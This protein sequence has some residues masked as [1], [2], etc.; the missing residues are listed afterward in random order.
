MLSHKIE[1]SSMCYTDSF[2]LLLHIHNN[3]IRKLTVLFHFIDEKTE[4]QRGEVT[5]SRIRRTWYSQD[6]DL[7][8]KLPPSQFSHNQ[9]FVVVGGG[10]LFSP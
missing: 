8:I 7:G 3:P 6:P 4:A 1:Q 5:C 10:G 9:L 2:F